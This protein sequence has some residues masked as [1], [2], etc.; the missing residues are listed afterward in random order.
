MKITLAVLSALAVTGLLSVQPAA[1][2][3]V[4]FA[5]LSQAGSGFDSMAST[6]YRQGGLTFEVLPGGNYGTVL[7]FWNDSDPSH[8]LGGAATTSLTSY[9]ATSEVTI[10]PVSGL[11]SLKSIDLAQWGAG[12]P[13]PSSVIT[14]S[15]L[16]ANNSTVTQSFTVPNN[17]GSPTLATYSFS[18]FNGLK[19]VSFTQGTYAAGGG[20]Q[21]D[22]VNTGGVPEPATWA[23]LIVGFGLVGAA[24]RGA[25]SRS[26]R[27][28]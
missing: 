28:V 13:G 15:G 7:G 25:R 17:S 6:S 8:P 19:Q 10:T 18:G 5:G 3:V 4:N 1:A 20:W 14:F 2:A 16:K 24:T 23:F 12:Q 26:L 27:P 11:F 22:N 21:F 9:Y